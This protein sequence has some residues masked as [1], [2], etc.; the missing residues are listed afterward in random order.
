MAL[1]KVWTSK[2]VLNRCLQE[3]V[4]QSHFLP[5]SSLH[6]T[7]TQH[8]SNKTSIVR[9][10][11]QKYERFY[12]LLLVQPDGSTINIRYK[13][14]KRIL[15]MPV[16]ISTLSEEERKMRMRK[17]DPRK[18]AVKQRTVEFEDDF[19]VDDYSKFWKK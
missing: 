14:P 16:D 8:N 12:P 1:Q 6:T 4:A 7:T 3:V 19:K 10:S 9:S 13:E 11:R 2:S 18:G 17:R 5:V 15:M